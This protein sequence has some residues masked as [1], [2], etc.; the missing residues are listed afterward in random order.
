VADLIM[1]SGAFLLATYHLLAQ[2]IVR[3][4]Y[5]WKVNSLG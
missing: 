2:R 1:N 5:F 4:L 3:E